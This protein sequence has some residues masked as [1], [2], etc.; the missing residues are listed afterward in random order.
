MYPRWFDAAEAYKQ[1][2]AIATDRLHPFIKPDSVLRMMA[3]KSKD[4]RPLMHSALSARGVMR[5][6]SQF[7]REAPALY[8]HRLLASNEIGS[9]R[10]PYSGTTEK[11]ATFAFDDSDFTVYI[12]SRFGIKTFV[13]AP[14]FIGPPIPDLVRARLV[15]LPE[16]LGV[17]HA[18]VELA[19]AI[20][21][22]RRRQLVLASRRWESVIILD[23]DTGALV[24]AITPRLSAYAPTTKFLSCT[25]DPRDNILYF[26]CSGPDALVAVSLENEN[27][28]FWYPLEA[29]GAT[30]SFSPYQN[31]LFLATL[32]PLKHKYKGKCAMIQCLKPTLSDAKCSFVISAQHTTEKIAAEHVVPLAP[33]RH[34]VV[35][36]YEFGDDSGRVKIVELR[37]DQSSYLDPVGHVILGRD[38]DGASDFKQSAQMHHVYA[39]GFR[40]VVGCSP[41]RLI[42]TR[43]IGSISGMTR[44]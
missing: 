39:A 22:A 17:P 15:P 32:I 19:Q 29:P 43:N 4:D 2:V 20:L 7:T 8:L 34:G 35:A 37:A 24:R 28:C 27:R 1:D 3:W 33:T 10:R 38:V 16:N 26:L 42:L 40:C 12:I 18:E 11:K 36:S 6:I 14:E 23:I 25:V 31:V 5:A 9:S 41:G 30:L 44:L 13:L 21:V